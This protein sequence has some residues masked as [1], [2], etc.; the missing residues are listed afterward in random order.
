MNTVHNSIY[1]ELTYRGVA[2]TNNIRFLFWASV[3]AYLIHSTGGISFSNFKKIIYVLF[4][5][6]VCYHILYLVTLVTIKLYTS[7]DIEDEDEDEDIKIVDDM[8]KN[9]ESIKYENGRQGTFEKLNGK[10]H[11][12]WKITYTNGLVA[13]EREMYKGRTHGYDRSWNESGQ[14]T[15]EKFY[16]RDYLNGR[17]RQW[18]DNGQIKNLTEWNMG[19]CLSSK[20]YDEKGRIVS[21]EIWNP[22]VSYEEVRDLTDISE[23]YKLILKHK[24]LDPEVEP[25]IEAVLKDFE[26][27]CY[28]IEAIKVQTD[29]QDTNP[30]GSFTGNIFLSSSEEM[31]PICKGVLLTPVIQLCVRDLPA[32][33]KN[34]SDIEYLMIF[35]HPEGYDYY[36]EESICIRAYNEL[37][38]L[39][40]TQRPK[41]ISP[42]T[43]RIKFITAADYPLDDLPNGIREYL[44]EKYN[45]TDN[46]HKYECHIENKISGWPAWVQSSEISPNEEFIMQ[47]NDY[48]WE[49]GDIPVLYIFRNLNSGE[50]SIRMQMH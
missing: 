1:E 27:Q 16:W 39:N 19:Q 43:K 9:I 7:N 32:I 5:L 41:E 12:L 42:N 11:G 38:A 36:N 46:Q 40:P 31:W 23:D 45:D 29:D 3:V 18:F 20:S 26:K 8:N 24:K 2:L 4:A 13:W 44:E 47:I 10:S 50:F 33:P 6:S 35:L 49:W 22:K 17:S 21:E 34:L 37:N 48:E 25:N 28:L 14:L 15:E 30:Y